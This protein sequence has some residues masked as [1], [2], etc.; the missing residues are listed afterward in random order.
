MRILDYTT[1]HE[2]FRQRLRDHLAR[3]LMPRL[4]EF[5][6][7]HAVPRD[8][9]RGLGRAGFLCTGVEKR[10]GGLGGDFLY[11][12]IVCGE[13]FR[14]HGSGF[15]VT[16][17]SDIVVPYISSYG[18]PAQ[19]DAWLPG[20]VLGDIITAVAM[21]EP[22][23]GSDLASMQATAVEAD[24]HVTLNGVKTF[25][26]NGVN[27]GLVIV[28]ARDPEVKNPHEA[29][30][31]YVVEENTPG[32]SRGRR[33]E[34][35]GMLA[36]DT[37]ELFF[38]NCR[39]P[40]ENRLGEKGLGFKMLMEKL[41]QERLMCVLMGVYLAERVLEA[42]IAH[43]RTAPGQNG[44]PLAK[45]QAAQFAIV[46]MSAEVKLGKVFAE[47]LVAAHARGEKAVEDISIAKYWCTEMAKRVADRALDFLGTEAFNNRHP[48]VRAWRDARVMS[49]FAGANEIMKIVAARQIGL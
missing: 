47:T 1:E 33:L 5:E 7:C 11:S 3:E 46:E 12:A 48:I 31:L 32:F 20:A 27:C 44:K 35:M 28:A 38:T 10:Y 9:W 42:L 45:E 2:A 18:S 43:A 39:V 19:K 26:S 6:S 49:I 15:G 16:L 22:G 24:G 4:E 8:F 36:Q 41:Q 29:I 30:S 13:M 34:K 40:V 17:H 23:A 37:A 21:T 14:C 25:I